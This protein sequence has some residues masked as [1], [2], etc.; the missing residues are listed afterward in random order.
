VV[1]CA[2]RLAQLV[3]EPSARVPKKAAAAI[4]EAVGLLLEELDEE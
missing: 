1:S 3:T 2:R 4:E